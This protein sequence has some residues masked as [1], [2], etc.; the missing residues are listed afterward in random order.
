MA[1]TFCKTVPTK[2]FGMLITQTINDWLPILY[3]LNQFPSINSLNY[4]LSTLQYY[5]TQ[6]FT[7]CPPTHN[8][9]YPPHSS[10]NLSTPNSKPA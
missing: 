5:L 3:L 2:M 8:H 1:T 9:P 7:S 4:K 10:N 6:I